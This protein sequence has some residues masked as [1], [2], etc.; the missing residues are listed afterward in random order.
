MR[1]DT[2]VASRPK[3]GRP[4]K[5]GA[6]GE[7]GAALSTEVKPESRA[8]IQ[9]GVEV[10]KDLAPIQTDATNN[11]KNSNGSGKPVRSSRNPAP[12]YVDAI[13]NISSVVW[14]AS[15]H[16]IAD[17]NRAIGSNK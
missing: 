3:R 8:E 9:N 5:K 12:K 13:D 15:A 7:S 16:D 1:P 6:T 2:E 10:N 17:L 11:N 14:T 4:A